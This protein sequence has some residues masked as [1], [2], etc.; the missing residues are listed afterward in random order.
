MPMACTS[1]GLAAAW[2]IAAAIDLSVAVQMSSKSCSTQ[3][4]RG[5]ICRNSTFAFPFTDR[6]ESRSS[7]VLPVVP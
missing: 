2:R 7:A 6:R 3:P 5:K 1:W 4:G